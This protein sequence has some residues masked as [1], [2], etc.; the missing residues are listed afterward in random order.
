MQLGLLLSAILICLSGSTTEAL[1]PAMPRRFHAKGKMI[2]ETREP[3]SVDYV[4]S[5]ELFYDD[6]KE[7]LLLRELDTQKSHFIM[8]GLDRVGRL[9]LFFY[10]EFLKYLRQHG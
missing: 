6:F 2:V 7:R 10:L 5:V 3:G 4:V 1:I 8:E 9:L